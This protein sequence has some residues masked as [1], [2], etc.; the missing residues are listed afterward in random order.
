MRGPGSC[1]SSTRCAADGRHAV[2]PGVPPRPGGSRPN[3]TD[4]GRRS[5]G[6]TRPARLPQRTLD[7]PDTLRWQAYRGRQEPPTGVVFARVRQARTRR[8]P[9]RARPDG[10]MADRA[11]C[12][13]VADRWMSA[14]RALTH[15]AAACAGP[16]DG[17]CTA[18]HTE[19]PRCAAPPATVRQPR[20]P[21]AAGSRP[22]AANTAPG[23]TTAPQ[24]AV[25]VDPGGGRRPGR[26]DEGEPARYHVL[27]RPG[28]PHARY[29]ISTGRS[30]RRS[31]DVYIGAPGAIVDGR[32]LQ[33]LRVHRHGDRRHHRQPDRSRLQA[34]A[35][36]GR[37]QPRLGQRLDHPRQH[38]R[39][40]QR[41]RA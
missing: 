11:H 7:L 32:G 34:A 9:R 28:Y 31:G 18:H 26:E 22:C 24:G 3:W 35:G 37:G 33:Q 38:D 2:P 13:S 15:R 17:A 6:P 4:R 14:L 1:G 27:A 20:A 40:Q 41:C 30:S 12:V 36:P 19:Q 21:D 8:H 25:T 29:W 39:G 5:L 16:A 23:P 10:A